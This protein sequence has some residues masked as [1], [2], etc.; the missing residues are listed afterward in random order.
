M[1]DE[2]GKVEQEAKAELMAKEGNLIDEQAAAAKLKAD[3]VVA[4]AKLKAVVVQV[5]AV[6]VAKTSL[7][8]DLTECIRVASFEEQKARLAQGFS[9]AAGKKR[10]LTSVNQDTAGSAEQ[11]TIGS[12]M[13]SHK[14]KREYNCSF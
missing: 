4:A 7:R 12:S 8:G 3:Q 6:P 11:A 5:E 14:R 2:A 1:H 13:G 10:A 9:P